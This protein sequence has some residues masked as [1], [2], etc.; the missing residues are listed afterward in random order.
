[1]PT[2]AR[3]LRFKF[4]Y[5]R[6]F[7]MANNTFKDLVQKRRSSRKFTDEELTPEDL[8]LI[9]RAGLMSPTGKSVRGWHFIV[10]D[11]KDTLIKLSQCKDAGAA[12]VAEVPVAVVVLYDTSLSD[13]WIEDASI[14]SVTMQYQA[15]DLGIGSCWAQ[16]RL[17]GLSDGTPSDEILRELLQYPHNMSALS[18]IA[19]G[20]PAIE[21]KMQDEDKL[22]WEN[23]HVNKF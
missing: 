17:R 8:Q 12:F 13:V 9:L 2:D 5:L 14:A 15:A 22:K 19:F 18:I 23:V 6:N 4:E 16:V 7:V 20:Y 1:M 11:D 10:V 21:R 3:I